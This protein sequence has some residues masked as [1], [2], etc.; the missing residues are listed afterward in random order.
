MVSNSKVEFIRTVARW[1]NNAC[2][3][4]SQQH[5]AAESAEVD[6]HSS[7]KDSGGPWVNTPAVL[8]SVPL[9]AAAVMWTHYN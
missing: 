4:S 6:T 9:T 1:K 7:S 2:S 8:R 3:I 5:S